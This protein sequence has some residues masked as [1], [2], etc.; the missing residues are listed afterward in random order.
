M[1]EEIYLI[2]TPVPQFKEV[3]PV[4]N[5]IELPSNDEIATEPLE[6]DPI[7]SI[8]PLLTLVKKLHP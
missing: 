5:T 4:S 2:N 8:I 7:P 3:V 6:I 1:S